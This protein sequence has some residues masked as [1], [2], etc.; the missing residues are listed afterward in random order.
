MPD[1]PLKPRELQYLL[2]IGQVGMEM[3][4]P[5]GLGVALDIWLGSMPWISIV[6]VLLGLFGGM[7]HL[8]VLIDRLDKSQKSE[9]S[10]SPQ[11]PQ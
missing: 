3:V 11:E 5:I 4:L 1:Q 7:A 9:P 10:N 8:L 6:G 2:A